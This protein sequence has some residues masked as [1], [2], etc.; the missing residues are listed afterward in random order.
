MRATFK[1]LN[2]YFWKTIYGPILSLLFPIILLSILGNIFRVEYVY[3]GI[4]AMSFL[5]IG[6]LSL[7]LT[8]MELKQSSLF[9]YIGSS[10]V[11]PVRF[12]IVVIFF[13][14]FMAILAALLIMAF[15]IAL[16][17]SK[18]LPNGH[19]TQG[20]LGGIFGTV[21]GA[22]SFYIAT[23][24]HLIFVI[25]VGLLIATISKT[26]QQSLTTGLVI[27]IPSI[28]LS[29]MVLSVDV[30]AQS[31]ALNWISRLIPFRY[32]TGNIV[33]ASTPKDQIGDMFQ[34]L[35]NDQLKLLFAN[36]VIN[37]D[38]SISPKT[39]WLLDNYQQYKAS[40]GSNPTVYV[41]TEAEYDLVKGGHI[42][43][44]KG[45]MVARQVL[46]EN[47]WASIHDKSL[48]ELTIGEA[49]KLN[50]SQSDNNIFQWTQSWAVRRIPEVDS[51]KAFIE[52]YFS[53]YATTTSGGTPDWT[54][55]Q[56]IAEQIAK[57]Q[58]GWLEIFM[59]QTN[60]LYFK[61]DRVLNMM[62]P[63][64]LSGVGIW[65]ISANFKWSN[66]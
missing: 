56:P 2:S 65:Y 11:N 63:L 62:L 37:A 57:G 42:A 13:Y 25:I 41:P 8:I 52:N 9:K 29:G 24:I 43:S 39:D 59:K 5:F 45:F 35:S 22:F 66:R 55:L 18:T 31:A 64:T 17:H 6:L 30:I 40:L 12:A 49:M 46:G 54:K 51:V 15:T 23:A 21:K 44:I 58:F 10:P 32:S 47:F 53:T 7:P 1:L 50:A 28:F 26:P 61:A 27:L 14:V 38:G 60:T 48:F 4:I 34:Q 16:F 20:I 3:P 33:I 19:I 36:E